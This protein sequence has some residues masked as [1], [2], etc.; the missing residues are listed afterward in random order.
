V[1]RRALVRRPGPELERISADAYDDD[2]GALV[3]PDGGWYWTGREAPDLERVAAQHSGLVTALR[4]EG[5][6]VTVA[7][8]LGGGYVKS[9]Y[10]RDPIVT[11]PGGAIVGRM[12]VRMRRGEEP[13]MTRLVADLGM[14]ILGTI[15]GTGT[16]EGGSFIKLRPGLA[17]FGISIRCNPNGA[18]Q[19]EQILQRI[20]WR[21]LRVPI[22]GYS[23]HLDCHMAMV[24]RDRA[25]VDLERLSYGFLQT[26]RAEGFELIAAD[27]SEDWALNALCLRPGRVL[28]AAG[29]PR[30]ADKLDRA[31]VEVITVDYDEI[32]KNGGGVHCSTI[33]LV[34]EAAGA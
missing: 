11:V 14:P 21:L 3:D 15:T 24:D 12:A 30:T 16:V 5:I 10:V 23:I 20:G 8:P 32:H 34:R 26:L 2:A 18:D 28:M 29:S 7:E 17:A 19:L 1:L 25:L 22:P 27:P 4:A 9:I 31:G 33:E 6:D 13:A